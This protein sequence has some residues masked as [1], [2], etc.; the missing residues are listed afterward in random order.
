MEREVDPM[1]RWIPVVGLLGLALLALPPAVSAQEAINLSWDNCSA[2]GTADKSFACNS[3]SGTNVMIAS[4]ISPDS[5]AAFLSAVTIIDLISATNPLPEWW[6]LRNQGTQ[7]NQCRTGSISANADFSANT[8]CSDFFSGQGSGGIGTYLINTGTPNRVRLSIVFA[9]PVQNQ[10]PLNAGE[11]YFASKIQINNLKTVG[12]TCTGCGD[13]VCIVLNG[14]QV[15]QPAGSPGGNVWVINEGT[16][17]SVTWQG[18]TGA[19]C[20]AVPARN[21]T[22]GQ[23]KALYR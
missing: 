4:F 5:M 17:R 21:R 23:V 3:N 16:R 14:V 1:K 13:P 6:E 22:W 10:G 7:T 9:V 20:L 18:G 2:A 19:D 15:V 11:E 12:T 8:G